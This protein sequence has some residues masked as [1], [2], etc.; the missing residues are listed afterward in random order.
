[1]RFVMLKNICEFNVLYPENDKYMQS[2]H[3]NK[4]I[5][6]KS[7]RNDKYKNLIILKILAN[8]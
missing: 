8:F 3:K 5:F 2:L 6:I 1:M 7:Y 4:S